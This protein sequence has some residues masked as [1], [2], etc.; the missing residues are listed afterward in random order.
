VFQSPLALCFITITDLARP[1]VLLII[2][3][4]IDVSASSHRLEEFNIVRGVLVDD[5][6]RGLAVSMI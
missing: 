2:R 5:S 3:R 6:R 4:S 1:L